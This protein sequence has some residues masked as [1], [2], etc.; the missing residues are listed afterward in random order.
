MESGKSYILAGPGR[1]GSSDPWLGVPINWQ[2][3]SKARLIIE[4]GHEN[5]PVDPSLEATFFKT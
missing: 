2:Q 3:I 1:W 4:I 5:F